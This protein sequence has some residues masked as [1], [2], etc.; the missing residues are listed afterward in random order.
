M[1]VPDI[2]WQAFTDILS[3]PMSILLY[4][5]SVKNALSLEK[6]DALFKPLYG[7]TISQMSSVFDFWI[8]LGLSPILL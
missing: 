7:L 1:K 5:P 3:I 2:R 4:A 8:A 6:Q